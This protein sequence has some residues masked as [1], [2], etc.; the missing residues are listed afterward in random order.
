MHFFSNHKDVSFIEAH[1]EE[2]CMLIQ[3]PYIE[4]E[5]SVEEIRSRCAKEIG[6]AVE[7]EKLIINGDY[8]LV[9]IILLARAEEGKPTGFLAMKKFNEP[10]NEKDA[11]GRIIHQNILKPVGIRWI[12]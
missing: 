9:A 8:T 3:H 6:Q 10:S 1:T 2:K 5:W 12:S 7:A 4:P 11:E